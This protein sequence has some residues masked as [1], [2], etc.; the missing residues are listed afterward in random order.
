MSTHE[1]ASIGELRGDE[2]GAIYAEY[3]LSV[4][5]GVCIAAALSAAGLWLFA[6][7]FA[8]IADALYSSTP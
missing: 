1:Q 2:R 7:R 6:P 3:V 5:A 8:R 4:I